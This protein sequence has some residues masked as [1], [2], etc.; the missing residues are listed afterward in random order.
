MKFSFGRYALVLALTCALAG[1]SAASVGAAPRNFHFTRTF[2]TFV[3]YTPRLTLAPLYAMETS[4][5]HVGR[6]VVSGE[7]VSSCP[8][9][10]GGVVVTCPPAGGS[11]LR[12]EIRAKRGTI[13]LSGESPSVGS[14]W[15]GGS[16]AVAEATGRFDGYVGTGSWTFTAG[17][18]PFTATVSI[19]GGRLRNAR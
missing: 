1:S 13:V 7:F 10:E 14:V 5:P 3:T 12:L 18:E 6:A 2:D 19:T 9:P 11:T 16:W 8:Y 17:P 15:I 4:I